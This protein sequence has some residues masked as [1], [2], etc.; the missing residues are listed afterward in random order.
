MSWINE[1]KLDQEV[2]RAIKIRRLYLIL[3]FLNAL[4]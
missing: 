2:R 3:A 4:I 1:Q